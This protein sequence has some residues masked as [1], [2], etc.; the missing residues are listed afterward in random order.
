MKPEYGK[1]QYN[2][3]LQQAD[4]QRRYRFSCQNFRRSKRRHHE[5]IK[6]SLFP[7]SG[8]GKPGKEHDLNQTDDRKKGWQKVP[9]GDLIWVIPGDGIHGKKMFSQMQI[10]VV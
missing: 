3:C 4:D 1:Q 7:F 9:P 6:G 2:Q 10:L 5:L 8:Y